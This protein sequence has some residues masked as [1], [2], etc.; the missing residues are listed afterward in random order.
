[1]I[2]ITT[3]HKRINPKQL[4]YYNCRQCGKPLAPEKRNYGYCGLTCFLIEKERSRK[5]EILH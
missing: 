2:Y 5:N 3:R 4:I 1:M